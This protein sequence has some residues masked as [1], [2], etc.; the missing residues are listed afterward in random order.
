MDI[1]NTNGSRHLNTRRTPPT[2]ISVFVNSRL[3]R[4]LST[5]RNKGR[6]SDQRGALVGVNMRALPE[7]SGSAAS[8]GE[9]D[10]FTFADGGFRF[11]VLNSS[12]SITRPGAVVG[13]TITSILGSFTSGLRDAGSFRNALGSVVGAIVGGRGHVVFGNGNCSRT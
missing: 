11:E 6:C 2:I 7:F 5:V 12:I 1:T 13:A 3:R 8:E 9:A 10:P 4:I